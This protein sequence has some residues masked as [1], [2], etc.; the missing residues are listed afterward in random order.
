MIR[1]ILCS[2]AL[3]GLMACQPAVPDS[4]AAA[5]RNAVLTGFPAPAEVSGAP[6]DPAAQPLPAS[7]TAAVE[8]EDSAGAPPPAVVNSAG[9]SAEQNFDAVSAER[10]IQSDA[11]RIAANRAQYRVIEPTDLPTRPGTNTPNI[12]EY[13]LRTNN[14]VGAQIYRRS[15]I[16][17]AQ[18]HAR[19]C[20]R[21]PSPDLAQTE[22]LSTGGP[23]RDR[24]GLDPDGDG[25][26]CAW[27]PTP[28]RAAR[29]TVAP[30]SAPQS[31]V[32]DPLTISSE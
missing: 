11:E 12:V 20:A 2:A 21:F 18:R 31:P 5:E 8:A 32:T 29:G 16:L 24:R 4:G 22:F 13:A 17:S 28:F 30:A 27:D 25:Y 10:S 7:V 19:N 26:A 3:A 14:P 15:N 23:E 1:V 9:I 6:L